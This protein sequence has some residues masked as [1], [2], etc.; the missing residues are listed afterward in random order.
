M[1]FKKILASVIAFVMSTGL[2]WATPLNAGRVHEER[3]VYDNFEINYDGWCN[4]GESTILSAVE[5]LGHNSTR[6]MM[7]TNRL[8]KNDG[9]YSQKGLLS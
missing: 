1:K 9:A 2:I 3:I 8:S 6:G 5:N 7:V 4:I